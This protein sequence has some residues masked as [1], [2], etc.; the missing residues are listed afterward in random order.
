MPNRAY[1]AIEP[2]DRGLQG[3]R[4]NDGNFIANPSNP[5]MFRTL[6][7]SFTQPPEEKEYSA[8]DKRV[9]G[10]MGKLEGVIDT[11]D[12]MFLVNYINKGGLDQNE[13]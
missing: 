11:D 5:N 13:N 4:D 8:D 10:I 7:P 9:A 1:K 3:K 12:L 6:P 2:I